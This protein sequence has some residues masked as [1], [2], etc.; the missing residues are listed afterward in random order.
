MAIESLLAEAESVADIISILTAG[1][2]ITQSGRVA[3]ISTP[4]GLEVK[5]AFQVVEANSLIISNM[6][7]G[8]V[9]PNFPAEL[10]PRDRTRKS[11]Q[12]QVQKI[13]TNLN[14]QRL[15]DSGLSSHGSPIIGHDN[16]V[17]S[18]NGRTMGIFKA[19]A[20]GNAETYRQYLIDNAELYG[21]KNTDITAMQ[22]PVLVRKRIDDIDRVKFAKDSN[23][24]DLQDMA[25]SEKAFADAESITP[26]MLALFAPADNGNLLAKSNDPFIRAFLASLGD[27]ATAG[28]LTADGRPTKQLV[29]RLQNAIFAKAY[30]NELLV[31]LVAEEPDPEIRN[32]LTALNVAAPDFIQMQYLS[33]ETH[34]QTVTELCESIEAVEGL[35]KKALQALVD[36][37]S[38][39]RAAKDSGQSI[40]EFVLQMG[41]FEDVSDEVRQLALFIAK[42]NR[43]SKRMGAAF[44][45]LAVVINEQLQRSGAAVNDMF[46][47]EPLTLADV[48]AA[49]DKQLEDEYGE[50]AGIQNA[51]F[52][53]AAKKPSPL[54]VA[55]E[56]CDNVTDIIT[57]LNYATQGVDF[58]NNSG[59]LGAVLARAALKLREDGSS[60][61]LTRYRALVKGLLGKSKSQTYHGNYD[62]MGIAQQF[63]K[64]LNEGAEPGMFF[65][66]NVIDT[67]MLDGSI[68]R[69]KGLLEIKNGDNPSLAVKAHS[70]IMAIINSF[71]NKSGN[72]KGL[73]KTQEALLVP[74]SA[75]AI[76]T[77]MD[78]MTA[79]TSPVKAPIAPI[80][81]DPHQAMLDDV[82]F[83]VKILG[84]ERI[85]M[86][87]SQ[88]K[89]T[90]RALAEDNNIGQIINDNY[91]MTRFEKEKLF[92]CFEKSIVGYGPVY[93][94]SE[95]NGFAR[96]IKK[97]TPQQRGYLAQQI[98]SACAGLNE[99]V[100]QAREN[101]IATSDIDEKQAND[102]ASSI[103]I[104]STIAKAL[105]REHIREQ[106][107]MIYKVC[108]GRIT[109]LAK[110]GVSRTGR[111]Y[112]IRRDNGIFL[113]LRSNDATLWHEAGHHF[114]Y[115]N[116]DLLV[117]AKAFLKMK[118]GAEPGIGKLADITGD[119]FG[120]KEIAILDNLSS[121]YAGRI[122][123]TDGTLERISS[124]EVISTAFEYLCNPA[125]GA[126][127]L[128]NDD[129]ILDFV[130]GAI[131][132]SA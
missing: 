95:E 72:L 93:A 108:R 20:E 96:H 101:L 26:E 70:E 64:T 36:A 24:S 73:T 82:N 128:M 124:T 109:T 65:S 3:Y 25:A 54:V 126:Q 123:S 120:P 122:Y 97:F 66:K 62:R 40:D 90:L 83:G 47:A 51:L 74:A 4:R 67:G 42:N 29:D 38:V 60:Q 33:G 5:T 102:W 7:N 118:A 81:D 10:Q 17:E 50:G 31:N 114:E 41:L 49:V 35:E 103:Q 106:L 110:I 104:S 45:A 127:S 19:Y 125:G 92:E 56:Q 22:Q 61:A 98:A 39:V 34:R 58:Y 78:I 48:L 107:R 14:P 86:R 69:L 44:K 8:T 1:S 46:G 105:G 52:E 111:A 21:L 99:I 89:E 9:N 43:S 18:G 15:A 59:P 87:R 53:S 80:I 85:K 79:I 75:G 2:Q 91:L 88:A 112:A 23:L 27:T 132:G 55:I 84:G 16:V 6:L 131:K 12:L 32:I 130:I 13:S 28:L 94:G 77:K 63:L 129:L 115:S 117:K 76:R 30:K 116:P 119:G 68:F 71:L 37:T 121:P 57:L 100:V 113:G 11:S